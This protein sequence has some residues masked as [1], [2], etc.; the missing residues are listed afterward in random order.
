MFGFKYYRHFLVGKHLELRTDH[1]DLTYLLKTPEPVGQAARYLDTLAEFDFSVLHRPGAQ[2]CNCDALSRR[3]CS[4]D[5]EQPPC[6]QYRPV[7]E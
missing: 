4:Q 3:P 2:H 6:R 7:S 5:T 1:D